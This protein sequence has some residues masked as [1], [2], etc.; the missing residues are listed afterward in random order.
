[1]R[2]FLLK[3]HTEDEADFCKRMG[4]REVVRCKDCKKRGNWEKCPA[5]FDTSRS[6]Y[7][8]WFCADGERK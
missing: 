2:E 5:C 3:S 4:M 8:D 6:I 7:N 1:M